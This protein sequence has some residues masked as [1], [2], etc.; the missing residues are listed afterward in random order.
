MFKGVNEGV[1]YESRGVKIFCFLLGHVM[2]EE[3]RLMESSGAI[4]SKKSY[5]DYNTTDAVN[6]D[7]DGDDMRPNELVYFNVSGRQFITT[8]HTLYNFP[9]SIIGTTEKRK[10]FKRTR[11]HEIFFDRHPLVFE[12]LLTFYQT[13]IL[14]PPTNVSQNI[15]VSD[16]KYFQLSEEAIASGLSGFEVKKIPMPKRK[17]QAYLWTILEYPDSSSLARIFSM[18]SLLIIIMSIVSFCWETIPEYRGPNL[19]PE[20]QLT[21]DI[22]ND[23]EIFCIAYFTFEILIRFIC[24]PQKCAFIKDFLNI[25]DLVSVLPFYITQIFTISGNVSIYFLR[26]VRLVRVFRVFKLSRH[27]N[28]MKI[29]GIAVKDS[30]RELG[31][32]L[33]FILLAVLLFSS[34]IYYA[35]DGAEDTKL[36]SIPGAFW[37]SVVTMTTVGYGDVFPTTIG[38]DGRSK[39]T[40]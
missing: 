4:D 12:S 27:S 6:I 23:I 35:E 40:Q 15:F 25:I 18:F 1:I 3:R 7:L 36:T 30:G 37:W 21:V 26:A 31:V 11:N 38:N 39:I 20:K 13:G 32:L 2:D 8:S 5:G 9:K 28:E 29:L 16:V 34:A 22:L 24:A 17:L 14:E 19:P 33:F 10:K